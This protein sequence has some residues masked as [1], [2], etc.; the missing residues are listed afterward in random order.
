MRSRVERFAA[1]FT[2]GIVVA[3]NDEE[4]PTGGGGNNTP[5]LTARHGHSMVYDEARRQLLLFG[6]VGTEG[7]SPSGDR[8]STWRWDGTTWT[9]LA[10]TGPSAR[11]EAAVTYDATRQRVVLY[12]GQSGVFPNITVL[13]DTWEWDGNAWTQR[14]T[15]GP[16]ARMHQ[17]IAFDRGRGKVVLYGGFDGTNVQELNDIWEWDG[18]S[19]TQATVSGPAN[20]TALGPVYDEKTAA[21]Y[22]YSVPQ[23]GGAISATR[24]NGTTLTPVTSAAPPCV[25][26]RRQ[27]TALGSNPGGL[28]FYANS[29]SLPATT[30]L[31]QTWRWDGS[32]WTSLTGTQPLSRSNAALAFDRDRN[33]VVL[34]GGEVGAGTPDLADTW[35]FD[36]TTWTR[37]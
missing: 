11:Y 16:G 18:T 9:R 3:C 24:W 30:I 19:W 8:N 31:P 14:A 17:A 32:T 12:G 28:F 5:T 21:L 37:R 26:V 25:P 33:R 13:A 27:F 10:T 7:T 29:C 6:G 35:E 34:Y 4:P 1:V 15:T 2:I 36:G 22:L 23:A 20:S